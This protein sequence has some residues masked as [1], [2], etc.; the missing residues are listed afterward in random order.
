[1]ANL[2]KGGDRKSGDFKLPP[3]QFDS[4]PA[5]SIERAAELTGTSVTQIARAREVIKKGKP[6]IESLAR[7]NKVSL[8]VA[9]TIAGLPSDEQEALVAVN[10]QLLH[11]PCYF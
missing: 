9:A 1:M 7:E 11:C 2:R 10:A 8:R 6:E 5:V 3:G 4:E